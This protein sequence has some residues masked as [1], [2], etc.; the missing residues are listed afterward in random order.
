[1]CQGEYKKRVT[2]IRSHGFNATQNITHRISQVSLIEDKFP[3]PTLF[4]SCSSVTFVAPNTNTD[5]AFNPRPAGC[6]DFPRYAGGGGN[7]PP[8]QLGS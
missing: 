2:E 5:A 8:F 4:E 3:I 7:I 1:M 6:L